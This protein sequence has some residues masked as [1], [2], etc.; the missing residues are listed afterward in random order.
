MSGTFT[1]RTKDLI[2]MSFDFGLTKDDY[3]I[4][5]ELLR[6]QLDDEKRWQ[7]NKVD[8]AEGG[9]IF[10][11]LNRKILDHY[12]Y[13]EIGQES[14]DMFRYMLNHK[15]RL[16]M[17][18][19]NQMLYSETLKFDPFSTMDTIREGSNKE[20]TEADRTDHSTADSTADG[21]SRSVSG[22]TPQV[23]LS[24]NA[25]YASAFTDA[26]SQS[27]QGAINDATGKTIGPATG[28]NTVHLKGSQGHTAALLMQWRRSFLNIEASIV[29]ELDSLFMQVTDVQDS[30]YERNTNVG[31]PYGSAFWPYF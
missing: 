5:N 9:Q 3:P 8:T 15:L 28:E 4:H 14:V 13:R 23:A 20:A 7:F 1:I 10:Y 30:M 2:D 6:G 21:K 24:G 31:L 17:P 19:Y 22:T 18:Y 29:N 12:F 25:D 26:N 11:G 16:I 27:S